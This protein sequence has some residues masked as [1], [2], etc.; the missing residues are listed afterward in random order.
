MRCP[1]CGFI[2]QKVLDSR[3]ARDGES[4][5][6]RRECTACNRRFTTFESPE[7]PRLFVVKRDGS[8]QEFDA[9]KCLD[10]MRIACRKRP[11]S[12][13]AMRDGVANLEREL[14]QHYEDEVPSSVIGNLVLA[15]LRKLDNVAFIRFASVYREFETL[16]DFREIVEFAS[17]F[18]MFRDGEQLPLLKV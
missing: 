17:E 13:D 7:R 8:R 9:E 6:R 5:R 12:I 18:P 16:D 4:I 1:Y 10:S 2:E 11:V 14:F 15:E 3:P